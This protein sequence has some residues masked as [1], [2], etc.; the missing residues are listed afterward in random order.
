MLFPGIRE[1]IKSWAG[2]ESS[3]VTQLNL[4]DKQQ[5]D[6]EQKTAGG[7][8]FDAVNVGWY[9]DVCEQYDSS[10]ADSLWNKSLR[11]CRSI[12]PPQWVISLAFTRTQRRLRG[13]EKLGSFSCLLL[14]APPHSTFLFARC[15]TSWTVSSRAW[16]KGSRKDGTFFG[17]ARGSP[18]IG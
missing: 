17:L 10:A 3:A 4:E 5:F 12:T 6:I 9:G 13:A 18:A 2:R 16:L 8:A 11:C 14:R 15:W 7:I 1:A